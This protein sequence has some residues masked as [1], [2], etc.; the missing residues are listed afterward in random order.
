MLRQSEVRN[1]VALIL[2]SVKE[3]DEPIP[4]IRGSCKKA[5]NL[6]LFYFSLYLIAFLGD[7][8]CGVLSD[9]NLV[10]GFVFV[11]FC[12][13]TLIFMSYTDY[14][15]TYKNIPPD[16]SSKSKL[17]SIFKRKVR[18]II[19]ANKIIWVLAVVVFFTNGASFMLPI[20]QFFSGVVSVFGFAFYMSRY[21]ISGFFGAINA[22]KKEF[23][24][25]G[26][27]SLF[28]NVDKERP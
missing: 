27:E 26:A 20:V 15:M 16:V 28:S 6:S 25:Q 21:Q 9:T 23:G 17:V 3:G 24:S 2:K 1:E 13:N 10:V 7:L 4:T 8:F 11:T 19:I 22:A 14:V 12:I 18:V 5:A